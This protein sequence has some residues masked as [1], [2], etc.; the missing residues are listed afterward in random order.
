MSEPG[1]ENIGKMLS[2]RYGV[3]REAALPEPHQHDPDAC[4]E[5]YEMLQE[6]YRD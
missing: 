5:C 2:G 4:D 3:V 1:A 6:S